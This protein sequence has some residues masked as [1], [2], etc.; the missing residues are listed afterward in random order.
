MNFLVEVLVTRNRKPVYE[1]YCIIKTDKALLAYMKAIKDA[2]DP[3]KYLT[4]AQY[5]H[6]YRIVFDNLSESQIYS[7]VPK[8]RGNIMHSIS[9][10]ITRTKY[11]KV[12][13]TVNLPT[14]LI[15]TV[16]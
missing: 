16:K 15:E 12:L 11:H 14:T 4:S 7:L 3:E 5:K 10:K 6:L 1:A 2:Y 9:I 13:Q 8:N